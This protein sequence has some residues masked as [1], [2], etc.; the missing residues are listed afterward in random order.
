MAGR[1]ITSVS[2]TGSSANSTVTLLGRARAGDTTA[3]DELFARYLPNLRRW[4]HGRLP[5][6]ARG[7]IDT[8][9]V[10]QDA[11]LQTFKN[12]ETF[13]HRGAGALQAY[14]RQAVMN[15]I[16][17][18]L[19]KAARRPAAE[20]LDTG[21]PDAG[22]SPLEEAIGA[23]AVARYD[24]ALEQLEA[25]ERELI[26]ARVELGFTYAE[27]AEATGRATANAA[28]MAVARALVKLAETLRYD[29]GLGR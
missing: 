16:R 18:E 28:R 12:I 4:A 13:D 8:Q 11:M 23:E 6:W 14:L 24:A 19:R 27:V 26:V 7:V 5:G 2:T 29:R 22:L 10:V 20:L 25:D 15:R 3:L 21:R 9:D 17:D 1:R